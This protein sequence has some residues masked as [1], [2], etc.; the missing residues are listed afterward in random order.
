MRC[1]WDLNKALIEA[2]NQPLRAAR[3]R[4]FPGNPMPSTPTSNPN[5]T[6]QGNMAERTEKNIPEEIVLDS[7]DEDEINST[8]QKSR[9]SNNMPSPG[10]PP[11]KR[12]RRLI[13]TSTDSEDE[14]ATPAKSSVNALPPKS[15]ATVSS[16]QQKPSSLQTSLHPKPTSSVQIPTQQK[17]T[18]V[19]TPVQQ[20]PTTSVQTPV[21]QKPTTSVQTSVQQKPTISVQTSVQQKPT[22]SVQTSLQQKPPSSMQTPSS[23]Q[24]S[25]VSDKT[26]NVPQALSIKPVSAS[27]ATSSE[28][29]S[30]SSMPNL[31]KGLVLFQV[32]DLD[33]PSTK[34][35]ET[36]VNG[37]I[38]NI[39]SNTNK[40]AQLVRIK[41]SNKI[42]ASSNPSSPPATS[43]SAATITPVTSSKTVN[44]PMGK[45][46]SLTPVNQIANVLQ[47]TE[48]GIYL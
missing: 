36:S 5:S 34:Q 20:K 27:S 7:S 45:G 3:K 33:S 19:Q 26:I 47:S 37:S 2:R 32:N 48:Q 35:E 8:S 4:G 13:S 42:T 39:P 40:S 6:N 44:I 16:V 12:A 15:H 21:Q 31:P 30:S 41:T 11:A 18:S 10:L 1:Q 23:V 17:P 24:S 38:S 9:S 22:T 46:V 28:K 14:M 43:S 29:A 25:S